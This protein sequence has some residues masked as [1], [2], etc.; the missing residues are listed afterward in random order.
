[1]VSDRLSLVLIAGLYRIFARSRARSGRISS[2]RAWAWPAARVCW[3]GVVAAVA[4]L[5]CMNGDIGHEAD[6]PYQSVSSTGDELD[7]YIEEQLLAQLPQVDEVEQE[8]I[9][10]QREHLVLARRM[11]DE[12]HGALAP[13][14]IT[15]ALFVPEGPVDLLLTVVPAGK[16]GRLYGVAREARAARKQR[17]RM[18]KLLGELAGLLDGKTGG[19][20]QQAAA[21]A[22]AER[23]ALLSIHRRTGSEA[24]I[25]AL[26]HKSTRKHDADVS[27]IAH[28]LESHAMDPVFVRRFTFDADLVED[29]TRYKSG[30]SWRVLKDVV[31]GAPVDAGVRA[32]LAS[33]MTG[34]FG[35]RAA[36][37]VVREAR[38]GEKYLGRTGG[39]FREV[40]RGVPY[41]R[42][43][44]DI[45]A[46]GNLDEMLLGEVKN[47]A[48]ETW[49]SPSQRS[50]LLEQLRRHNDG[51]DEVRRGAGRVVN[52]E[53]TKVL[54]VRKEG[55]EA[56]GDKSDQDDLVNAVGLLGWKT[57]LIPSAQIGDFG[58]LIRD[59]R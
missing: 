29:I 19:F 18:S 33:K 58:E 37:D 8:V 36:A 30:P 41:G 22:P 59:L 43:S 26:L 24:V 57:E 6:E 48:A 10:L 2:G 46:H 12:M 55:F 35:E 47:W 1:M 53:P 4:M 42:G 38:F 16:L 9:D 7:D 13:L 28:K 45:V 23:R 3:V 34:L 27:W 5:G 40:T 15:A 25:S 31:N 54:F 44:I 52:G 39:R 49:A 20:L 56:W 32:S 21:L 11:G 17:K 50:K 14:A 51:I